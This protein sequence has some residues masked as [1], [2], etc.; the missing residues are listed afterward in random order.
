M[1]SPSSG[2]EGGDV[3]SGVVSL[4]KESAVVY[5]VARPVLLPKRTSL[6]PMYIEKGPPEV[7]GI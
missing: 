3:E 5:A 4:G 1:S 6:P 2:A 7:V